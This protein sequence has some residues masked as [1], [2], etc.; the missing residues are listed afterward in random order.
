MG[1]RK[2]VEGLDGAIDRGDELGAGANGMPLE[3]A[4]LDVAGGGFAVAGSSG[5][6][7]GGADDGFV[8]WLDADGE[9]DGVVLDGERPADRRH[10][11]VLRR[12]IGGHRIEPAE[13]RRC[14]A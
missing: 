14:D 9:R 3:I 2:G 7:V 12:R 1:S 10:V 11:R 5:S 4:I 6:G 13:Q 8:L